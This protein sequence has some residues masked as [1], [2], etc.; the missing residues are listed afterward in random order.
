MV[1]KLLEVANVSHTIDG[2]KVLNNVS[3]TIENGDKVALTGGHSI[4]KTT[5]LQILAGEITPEE[6]TIHWGETTTHTYFPKRQ[7]FRLL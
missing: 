5:L 1:I 7:Q 4:S 3:F 2:E 6:G